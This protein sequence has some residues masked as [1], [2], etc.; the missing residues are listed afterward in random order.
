MT[1]RPRDPPWTTR[2]DGAMRQYLKIASVFLALLRVVRGQDIHPPFMAAVSPEASRMGLYYDDH[3]RSARPAPGEADGRCIRVLSVTTTGWGDFLT[4]ILRTTLP[5]WDFTT[6]SLTKNFTFGLA[7]SAGPGAS[8]RRLRDARLRKPWK[9]SRPPRKQYPRKRPPPQSC[10]SDGIRENSIRCASPP[11]PRDERGD[12]PYR[13]LVMLPASDGLLDYV[14]KRLTQQPPEWTTFDGLDLSTMSFMIPPPDAA[15][16][17]SNKQ[18]LATRAE[19]DP[20]ARRHLPRTYEVGQTFD[21]DK[22]PVYLKKATGTYSATVLKAR[23]RSHFQKLVATRVKVDAEADQWFVQEAIKGTLEYSVTLLVVYGRI[24][25][26]AAYSLEFATDAPVWPRN[27]PLKNS[28]KVHSLSL[29]EFAA[30]KHFVRDYH[31]IVNCNYKLDSAGKLIVIEFNT[32]ISGDVISLSHRATRLVLQM[33]VEE[34][35]RDSASWRL[36]QS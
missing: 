36:S 25:F 30:L 28:T 31:G 24:E 32:R 5:Q 26:A 1:R 3:G 18:A 16:R 14:S 12:C 33:Y 8:G 19:S 27:R 35:L 4:E 13:C 11:P 15:H 9:V 10:A 21:D 7:T 23:D 2:W 34:S 6:C 29:S 17:L 22:F 20:I